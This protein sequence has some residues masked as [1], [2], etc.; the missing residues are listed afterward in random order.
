MTKILA[1]TDGLSNL[2]RFRLMPGHRFDM[3]G[4]PPLLEGVA[5]GGLIADKAFDSDAIVADLNERGA[6]VVI[7]QHPRR[8]KS[9]PLDRDLD[10]WRNLI[11]NFLLQA[12]RVQTYRHASLQN[13]PKL[14]GHDLSRR[15]L[16]QFAMNP[17]GPP[18]RSAPP[19]RASA[20]GNREMRSRWG[21]HRRR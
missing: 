17:N 9:L 7:S 20:A 18:S 5:F 3:V 13:R 12:Q 1:L 8:A 14:L 21:R 10:E 19:A 6:K 4:V 2:V 16:H 11:E 15:C